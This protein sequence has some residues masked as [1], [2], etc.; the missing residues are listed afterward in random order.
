M[1][2][3][4]KRLLFACP[5]LYDCAIGFYSKFAELPYLLYRPLMEFTKNLGHPVRFIQ[6][7]AS[8]GLKHDLL[9]PFVIGRKWKGVLVEPI[10]DS[11]EK[12]KKI[13]QNFPAD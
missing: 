6:L 9:R 4:I 10:P 12:L 13:M 8:D 11:F 5:A 3:L 1:K 2:K 7:G